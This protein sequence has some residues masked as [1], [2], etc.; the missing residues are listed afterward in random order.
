MTPLGRAGTFFAGLGLLASQLA[1]CVVLNSV[2]AGM[3]LTTLCP[4]YINL[5]RGAYIITIIGIAVCPWNYVNKASTF[6][7]YERFSPSWDLLQ[8]CIVSYPMCS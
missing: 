3:D 8:L 2:A 5:R 6:L 4:K 7:R 1:L